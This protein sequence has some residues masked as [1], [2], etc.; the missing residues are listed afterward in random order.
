MIESPSRFVRVASRGDALAESESFPAEWLCP[1][2]STTV[3]PRDICGRSLWIVA[4]FRDGKARLFGHAAIVGVDEIKSGRDRGA[5]VLR[6]D[7]RA[8][9]R[10]LPRDR[11]ERRDWILPGFVAESSLRKST[12]AEIASI[13]NRLK[14]KRT[15]LAMRSIEKFA[16]FATGR[17]LANKT[18]RAEI[19]LARAART[20]AYGEMSWLKNSPFT[21]Y[22]LRLLASLPAEKRKEWESPI[23]LADAKLRDIFLFRAE[24]KIVKSPAVVDTD[25]AK[26]APEDIRARKYAAQIRDFSGDFGEKTQLAEKI[27]QGM[28]RAVAELLLARGANPLASTSVDLAVRKGGRLLAFEMKSANSSNF[29][30]Q[31]KKGIIQSLEYKMWLEVENARVSYALVIQSIADADRESAIARF[32]AYAGIAAIFYDARSD[33][34]TARQIDDFLRA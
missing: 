4:R 32:A 24:S 7:K 25:L 16:P 26:I 13:K 17:H 21:P 14:R 23:A 29:E 5:I 12:P 31:A 2:N 27:H 28:V 30:T 19:F 20:L 6:A 3:A 33:A 34:K 8:S 9:F 22:A 11:R 10:I 18:I 1:R 15:H